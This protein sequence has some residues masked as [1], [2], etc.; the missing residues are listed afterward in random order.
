MAAR[1]SSGV[2]SPEP[3]TSASPGGFY[4]WWIV[5]GST[6]ILFVSSGIGFYGHGAILDPLRAQYGWSKGVIS[7]AITM[8]FAVAGAMG[9]VVGRLTDRYGPRPMLILGSATVGISFF[10]LSRVTELWQ[11][12]AVYILMSVGWSGASLVTINTLIA[13]WF[14]RRRG[15]A[16]G[17]T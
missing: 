13:N 14:F 17:L 12:F 11:F 10:L 2:E 15:F 3:H 16:M 6:A 4:G 8:Y 1:T 7:S 9:L 5:L